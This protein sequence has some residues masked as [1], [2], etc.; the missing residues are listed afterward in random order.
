MERFDDFDQL[1]HRTPLPAKLVF[2]T[3]S[4]PQ[5]AGTRRREASSRHVLY[6]IED[7]CLDLRL[8]R[9]P[10]STSAIVVGQLAD[11]ED[12]L[13]PLAGLTVLLVAGEKFVGRTTSNRQGEFQME[14]EPK[15]ALSLCLP[16]DAE[17]L[18][19]VPVEATASLG[20]SSS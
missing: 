14:Y 15:Q 6:E 20:E 4:R 10:Q 16:I 9:S 19:E 5:R 18:I 13:K 1:R 3:A 8:D 12:P 17:R 2:D 11:R 7:L